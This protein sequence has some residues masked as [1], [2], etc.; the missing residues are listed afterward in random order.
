MALYLDVEAFKVPCE[1]LLDLLQVIS[2]L[3]LSRRWRT[4]LAALSSG[5]LLL[6][7]HL[8]SP[9]FS[10]GAEDLRK[11]L[12]R[13]LSL[14][15]RLQVLLGLVLGVLLV[16]DLVVQVILG[17]L[18]VLVVLEDPVELLLVVD[19]PIQLVAQHR[20]DLLGLSRHLLIEL[21]LDRVEIVTY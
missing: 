5:C 6:L 16:L 21:L 2:C 3:G 14:H 12:F 7:L 11:H 20:G 17:Q 13:P 19:N 10:L 9:L 1:R 15:D 18:F 4:I 8:V